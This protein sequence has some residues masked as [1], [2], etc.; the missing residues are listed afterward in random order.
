MEPVVVSAFA[1]MVRRDAS[2][3]HFS[4]NS[5]FAQSR[6][7]SETPSVCFAT[8]SPIH[9]IVLK[10]RYKY[11]R[12][13]LFCQQYAGNLSGSVFQA[14]TALPSAVKI[15]PFSPAPYLR[16][17]SCH[18]STAYGIAIQYILLAFLFIEN[19]RTVRS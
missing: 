16:F 8:V 18:T 3:N 4:R 7:R 14:V 9:N 5:A 12:C 10:R 15:Q 19:Y 6:I 13:F 11:S 17:A 2:V 1:A